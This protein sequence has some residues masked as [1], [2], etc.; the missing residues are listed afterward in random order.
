MQKYAHVST[1][2]PSTTDIQVL[3]HTKHAQRW[4]FRQAFPYVWI[5][6]ADEVYVFIYK[7]INVNAYE[8]EHLYTL[9]HDYIWLRKRHIS[10][11][12][13]SGWQKRK[14]VDKRSQIFI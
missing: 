8:L 4:R 7:Q 2:S 1:G 5:C 13:I 6:I 3:I 10:S 11:D 14:E 12:K 9:S